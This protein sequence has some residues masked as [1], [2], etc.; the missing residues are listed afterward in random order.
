MDRDKI[1]NRFDELG[2]RFKTL[3]TQR[4]E[5]VRGHHFHGVDWLS[6]A[7]SAQHLIFSVFGENSIHAKNINKAVA[8]CN[9]YDYEF[10]LVCAV[11]L[12]AHD[13]FKGGY[14]ISV[15]KSISG[16]IF[17]DFIG[18]ARAALSEGHK[19]VAAVLAAAALEDAIKRFCISKEIDVQGKSLQDLVNAMK[20]KSLLSGSKKS[21]L[22]SMPRIRDNAMHA[23]WDKITEADIGAMIGFLDQFLISE[24]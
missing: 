14:L 22:D 13:D 16:E 5:G 12:S 24:F 6:W 2:N 1:L 23:H 4:N 17:G 8:D 18:M 7:T 3:P 20:S 10:E 15:E 21:L 9:G 11:F 19:N